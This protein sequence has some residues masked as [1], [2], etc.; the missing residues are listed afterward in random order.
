M[1]V[2]G[3]MKVYRRGGAKVYQLG[4]VGKGGRSA[5]STSAVATTALIHNLNAPVFC[6]SCFA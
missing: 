5:L 2:N 1:G 3:G 4:A 6:S